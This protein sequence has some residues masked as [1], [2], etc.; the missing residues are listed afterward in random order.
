[1][2]I[3]IHTGLAT[4]NLDGSIKFYEEAFSFKVVFKENDILKEIESITGI[5]NQKCSLAH[6]S[7]PNSEHIIELL[8]FDG[9][10]KNLD[11]NAPIKPGQAHISF[12]SDDFD[13]LKDKVLFLGAKIIGDITFFPEGRAAYF[14][15]PYGTFFELSESK[16]AIKK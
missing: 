10:E 7:M 11:V 14:Y 4:T 9:Q 5:V 16:L 1:M 6:L 13:K 3:L 2:A 15:E 12:Q 8:Q